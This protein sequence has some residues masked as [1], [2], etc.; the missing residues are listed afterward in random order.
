MRCIHCDSDSDFKTRSAHGRCAACG[1]A[2]AF[3]P[4]SDK[5]L[6]DLTFKLA[7]D[8]VSERGALFW[9]RD[10][11]YYDLCRRV[12]SRRIFHRVIRRPRVSL[13]RIEFAALYRRWVGAHGGHPGELEGRQFGPGTA[14]RPADVEAYGFERLVVCEREET[15]D[16]LLANGFHAELK[17]PVLAYSGYPEHAYASLLPLLRERPPETVV[18]VHDASR[19]GCALTQAVA[20]SP[21]WF[22]GVK[23]PQ[24]VDAGL[25]PEDARRFRGLYQH[26]SHG[27]G[28][29]ASLEPA[30]AKWLDKYLLELAA[31]RPRVLMS[32][33]ARILRG[34]SEGEGAGLAG[35]TA[36]GAGIVWADSWEDGDDDVG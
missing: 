1:R 33:L 15:A 29:E 13:E 10:Q 14:A 28:F 34:E 7:L 25:R 27:G 32:V 3:E 23:L 18:V 35:A 8:G 20:T 21:R 17:C 4:R 5:G 30:D 19:E 11:L 9:T 12:R 36:A 22:A 16:V 24:L 2:F 6:T 26:G 31:A